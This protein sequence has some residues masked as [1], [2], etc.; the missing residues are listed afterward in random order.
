MGGRSLTVDDFSDCFPF[1]EEE[2]L[3]IS[4]FCTRLINVLFFPGDVEI[5][6]LK[7]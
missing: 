5:S 2:C 6:F 7:D 3:I 1:I 4:L